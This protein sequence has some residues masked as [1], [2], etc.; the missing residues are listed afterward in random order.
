[1]LLGQN[2]NSYQGGGPGESFPA[3]LKALD[4]LGVPRVRFMTSH[5][6]DLSDELIR[7]MADS[8]HICNHLHLP[9]QSGNDEVLRAMNRGYTREGYLNRVRLLREA[10]PHIG[11]TTDF[12]VGFPGETEAQFEDSLS[13]VREVGYD[14]AFSFVFSPRQGTRAALLP[15][16]VE[17][18]VTS[19]RMERL[20]EVL[21]KSTAQVHQSMIG[22]REEVLVESISKRS[23]GQVSGKGT[24]SITVTLD[25]T[26]EDIGRV[27]PVTIASAAVNTLRGERIKGE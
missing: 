9:V 25:G 14:A 3:L 6:K 21:A 12:I 11:L 10:M 13:L 8:R 18:A 4:G 5:P 22:R 16:Q 20:L 1:M 19:R 26:Q 17:A 2:V 27:V 7:V 23:P 24:R 15:G